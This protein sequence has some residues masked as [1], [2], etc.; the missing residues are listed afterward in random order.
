[1]FRYDIARWNTWLVLLLCAVAAPEAHALAS[2]CVGT[3]SAFVAALDAAESDNDDSRINLRTGV[4]EF[5]DDAY[6]TSSQSVRPREGRLIIEGGYG[7]NCTTRT[8]DARSTTLHGDG[9]ATIR[10]SPWRGSIE[11][12][13][14][15][16][17]GVSLAAF[18]P[19]SGDPCLAS[20]LVFDVTRV[21]M[22]HGM[23][24]LASKC[25]DI[26]LRDTLLTNGY[27]NDFHYTFDTALDVYL[28][29]ETDVADPATLTL[30]GVTV[31]EGYTNL[32]AGSART[33][34]VSLYNSIFR[35]SGIDIRAAGVNVY[36][37]NNR[38]DRIAFQDGALVLGSSGNTSADPDFD[39]DY[40]PNPGSPMIDSGTAGVPNGLGLLDLFAGAR[41]VGAG[42]DRGA[43]ER[44]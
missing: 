14:L 5:V 27:A 30:I 37:R 23:M 7:A 10:L 13:S 39:A 15:G 31:A 16:F 22:N 3:Q 2:Y 32:M 33:G 43:L 28:V 24:R 4:Y 12:R 41:V 25:H 19:T 34:T 42:V 17:D 11:V 21:R 20:G 29:Q 35:R 18:G 8:N 36:A 44:Q 6:Y 1:M 26:T 40:R 38:Y 9:R